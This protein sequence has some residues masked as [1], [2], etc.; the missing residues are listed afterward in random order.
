MRASNQRLRS[1]SFDPAF[2]VRRLRAEVVK[3]RKCS[4]RGRFVSEWRHA[5]QKLQ[6]RLKKAA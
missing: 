6:R 1:G 4:D 3:Q 2:A 5:A